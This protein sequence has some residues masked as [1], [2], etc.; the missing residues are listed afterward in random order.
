MVAVPMDGAQ[1]SCPSLSCH[2]LTLSQHSSRV[3]QF[4]FSLT[5]MKE[6]Q[7]VASMT[8]GLVAGYK[9]QSF[10]ASHRSW[11]LT[12][13]DKSNRACFQKGG[14]G[15][16]SPFL[17]LDS[18]TAL[19][20]GWEQMSCVWMRETLV[21]FLLSVSVRLDRNSLKEGLYLSSRLQKVT[22]QEGRE[23]K[24]SRPDSNGW[25]EAA[26]TGWNHMAKASWTCS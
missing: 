11:D 8:A 2:T 15:S 4:G 3:P 25:Q 22:E 14:R 6:G 24:T 16:Y 18:Q 5:A 21:T 13:T 10:H 23:G 7:V 12:V 1:S 20:R 9:S 26:K 19:A 17:S